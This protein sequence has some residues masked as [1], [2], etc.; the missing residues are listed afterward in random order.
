MDKYLKFIFNKVFNDT[1]VNFIIIVV[2]FA[3]DIYRLVK[4][5]ESTNYNLKENEQIFVIIFLLLG[6]FMLNSLMLKDMNYKKDFTTQTR[7]AIRDFVLLLILVIVI[8]SLGKIASSY[9]YI[10]F[11]Y[12][13]FIWSVYINFCIR[14]LNSINVKCDIFVVTATKAMLI[15]TTAWFSLYGQ[16]Q[17]SPVEVI[18]CFISSLYPILDMYTY[19]RSKIYHFDKKEK[20]KQ[21]FDFY[22][23]N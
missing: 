6:F 15:A 17:P 14:M 1:N 7:V 20:E 16:F 11:Y 9:L 10:I 2:L 3:I 19:A 18:I 13:V 21:K 8:C 5:W 23:Y 22:N 12:M 4:V